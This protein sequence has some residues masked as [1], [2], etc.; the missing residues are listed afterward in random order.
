MRLISKQN[1]RYVFFRTAIV[2]NGLSLVVIIVFLQFSIFFF[3]PLSH[4][5]K[6]FASNRAYE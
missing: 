1:Q 3:T 2:F 4:N 6:L 5:S